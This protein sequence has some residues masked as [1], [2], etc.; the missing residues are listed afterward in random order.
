[1]CIAAYPVNSNVIQ[2]SPLHAIA[3]CITLDPAE[4]VS[5]DCI[6][7]ST[8]SFFVGT[9]QKQ[10]FT[11]HFCVASVLYAVHFAVVVTCDY[12]I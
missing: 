1:M 11:V 7:W 2:L 3:A 5:C 10:N 9:F 8:P 6:R 12:Q 4:L